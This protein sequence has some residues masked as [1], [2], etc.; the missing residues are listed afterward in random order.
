[1]PRS[2]VAAGCVDFVLPPAA[3]ARELARIGQHPYLG[4]APRTKAADSDDDLRRIFVVL[5][6]SYRRG[7]HL[8]QAQHHPAAHRP[9]DARAQTGESGAI[10]EVPP[11]EPRRTGSAL[12]GH[13][14]SRHGFLPGAGGLS[15]AGRIC[16]PPDPRTQTSRASRFASGFRAAPP[17]KKRTPSPWFW[18]NSWKDRAGS[19]P[20]QIFGTDISEPAIEK[21]RAG[22]VPRDRS[23]R[24]VRRAPAAI[25]RQGRGRLPD[26]QIHARDV[27]LRAPGSYPGSSLLAPGPDQLPQRPHL[28]GAG[29]PG[30]GDRHL[31]LRAQTHRI[32][33]CSAS[34]SL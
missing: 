4:I 23:R 30:E 29:A 33:R 21:A 32:P 17:A 3:I 11:R 22:R 6:K 20:I 9:P 8:L 26:R 18:R 28:H 10:S 24:G 14:D 1:M 2:A 34:P 16:P 5:E 7:F 19:R 13:P 25:L 12:R 15:G 31:P 27:R